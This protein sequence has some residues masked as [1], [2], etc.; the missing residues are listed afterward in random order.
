[1]IEI[2][3]ESEVAQGGVGERVA[4]VKNRCES[5]A[6]RSMSSLPYARSDFLK[7]V[8]ATLMA[9]CVFQKRDSCA[10]DISYASDGDSL[11][12]LTFA[13]DN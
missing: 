10:L 7:S 12:R 8:L 9:L 1:M 6:K 11:L 13:A 3:S 2:A 5:K 4:A